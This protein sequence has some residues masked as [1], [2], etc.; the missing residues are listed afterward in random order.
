MGLCCCK[1]KIHHWPK[2]TLHAPKA[3]RIYNGPVYQPPAYQSRPLSLE[4]ADQMRTPKVRW[5]QRETTQWRLL[6]NKNS[7]TEKGCISS[8]GQK[9]V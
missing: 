5:G 7:E 2:Q 4:E 8:I 6:A 9:F 1:P 3:R